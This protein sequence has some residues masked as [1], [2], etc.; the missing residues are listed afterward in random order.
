ML[1]QDIFSTH[2]VKVAAQSP[3]F[4]FGTVLT[5]NRSVCGRMHVYDWGSVSRAFLEKLTKSK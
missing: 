5:D 1:Q 4:Q 2:R 3:G